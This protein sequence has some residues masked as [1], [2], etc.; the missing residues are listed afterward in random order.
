MCIMCN[1]LKFLVQC[2]G[3]QCDENLKPPEGCCVN[4]TGLAQ[5]P[6]SS[7]LNIN[8]LF[9]LH[10]TLYSRAVVHCTL[11]RPHMC[12]TESR[13]QS[14]HTQN[15]FH[16]MSNVIQSSDSM[17]M[18]CKQIVKI[19]NFFWQAGKYLLEFYRVLPKIPKFTC[20]LT[21]I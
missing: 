15:T 12:R 16:K 20:F 13:V 14:Q 21:N 6:G 7:R 4:C 19:S 9:S 18:P 3:A 8:P 11:Q 10:S 1:G 17:S 5:L 2:T